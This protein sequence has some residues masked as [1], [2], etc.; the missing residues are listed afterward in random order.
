MPKGLIFAV[1]AL[2]AVVP[3]AAQPATGRALLISDI[4]L[5]P[6]A[7]KSI[8]KELIARPANEW[9][10][11]FGTGANAPFAKRGSDSNFSLMSAVLDAAAKQGPFDYILYQG[12]ALSHHFREALIAAGGS[13]HDLPYFATKTAVFVARDASKTGFMRP[14][15]SR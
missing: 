6:F 8:V 7:D 11:I 14:C 15:F 12:D 3:V 9:T 1:A 13:D 4:H 5:D 10:R 2:A